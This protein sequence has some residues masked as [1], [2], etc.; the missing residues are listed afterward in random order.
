[1]KRILALALAVLMSFSCCV[2]VTSA[3][4]IVPYSIQESPTISTRLARLFKG[5]ER[6]KL[7]VSYTVT[8]TGYAESI[9]LAK[10]EMYDFH[11]NLVATIRGSRYEGT[12][13]TGHGNSGTVDFYGTP[14][15]YYYADVTVFATIGNVYDEKTIFTGTVLCPE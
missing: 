9:G 1:M 2:K 8:S 11:N 3:A 14:G 5:D 7:V 4:E 12:V 10:V 6:G 15:E 13:G